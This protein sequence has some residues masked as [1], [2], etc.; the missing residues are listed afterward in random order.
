MVRED[1]DTNGDGTI[2]WHGWW[3]YPVQ[4]L[5][6]DSFRNGPDS[7]D[8]INF[9]IDPH[10]GATGSYTLLDDQFNTTENDSD[11][12]TF[13]GGSLDE[14]SD[15]HYFNGGWG[16]PVRMCINYAG[17]NQ[18]FQI[19][20]VQVW[21][22]GYHRLFSAP[23]DT[24]SHYR[25]VIANAFRQQRGIYGDTV[26]AGW[27]YDEWP[28]GQTMIQTEPLKSFVKVNRILQDAG[29]PTLWTNGQAG[30]PG[31]NGCLRN[32]LFQQMSDQ[33]V[34]MP[35]HMDEFYLYGGGRSCDIN[36]RDFYTNPESDCTY[37]VWSGC[38][39]DRVQG[40]KSLQCTIDEH[41]WGDSIIMQTYPM[42]MNSGWAGLHLGLLDQIAFVREDPTRKFWAMIQGDDDDPND[43][44]CEGCWIIRQPTPNEVKLSAWLAVAC[45]VDGILWYPVNFAAGLLRWNHPRADECGVSNNL[46][47]TTSSVDTASDGRYSAAKKAG[48]D[49]LEVERTLESLEF[50]KTYASRAY[51]TNYPNATYAA[52][53][54]D[55]LSRFPSLPLQNRYVSQIQAFDSINGG[56]SET[57]EEHPYVQVSRFRNPQIPLYDP[58]WEDYW[59]LIVNRRALPDETRK[60][61]LIVQTAPAFNTNPYYIH[62]TLGDMT[63]TD[64]C[65]NTPGCEH[66]IDVILAPGEAQLVHFFRGDFGCDSTYAHI[67]NL[68]AIPP[69]RMPSGWRGKRSPS[70]TAATPSKSITTLS[71]PPP[72]TSAPTHPSAIPRPQALSIQCLPFSRAISI[73]C[74]PAAE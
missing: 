1:R 4:A 7:L 54:P 20:E 22:E 70:R 74:R 8:V 66:H 50:V 69:V 28:Q 49:I 26:F 23:P 58:L 19:Y 71:V 65:W 44:T 34:S 53:Q 39:N 11:R 10:P 68:T 42:P 30:W 17:D 56:W 9:T 31:C 14:N 45:D 15:R 32:E 16:V 52:T 67:Q 25:N 41:L 57:P 38:P 43:S 12:H 18:T 55:T 47:H 3:Q 21:D 29:L 36:F 27:Y 46:A 24:I 61:R 37:I 6:V 59:F 73:R 63:V 2:D 33:S 48:N 13:G 62:H 40:T 64:Q 60:I 35:V 5:T 51:E 72:L